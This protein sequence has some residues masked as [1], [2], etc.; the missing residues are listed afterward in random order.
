[1]RGKA[2][3]AVVADAPS[4]KG[5]LSDQM[6]TGK[7]LPLHKMNSISHAMDGVVNSTQPVT[8]RRSV[9]REE[10][11]CMDDAGEGREER[12]RGE[13]RERRSPAA[14]ARARAACKRAPCKNDRKAPANLLW[15]LRERVPLSDTQTC[16]TFDM[17]TT[18]PSHTHTLE[19][20]L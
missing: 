18:M 20:L 1:M 14:I 2:Q 10:R 12:G 7:A 6:E 13:R 15:L 5:A 16:A 19:T 4:S 17:L 8:V 3:K 11:G 9:S